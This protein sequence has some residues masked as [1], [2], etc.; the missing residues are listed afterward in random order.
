M[1]EAEAQ[2]AELPSQRA[3]RAGF[4]LALLSL[5]LLGA[6]LR[7]FWL[8]T[9]LQ[10]PEHDSWIYTIEARKVAEQGVAAYLGGTVRRSPLFPLLAGLFINTGLSPF[11]A[12][13]LIANAFYLGTLLGTFALARLLFGSRV[14]ILATALLALDNGMLNLGVKPF[15]DMGQACLLTWSLFFMIK[16]ARSPRA[17][18]GVLLGSSLLGATFVRPEGIV[19]SAILLLATLILASRHHAPWVALGTYLVGFVLLAAPLRAE[20]GSR[21]GLGGRLLLEST[22]AYRLSPESTELGHWPAVDVVARQ[23]P[24]GDYPSMARILLREPA[25]H[26]KRL[27]RNVWLYLRDASYHLHPLLAVFLLAGLIH[28]LVKNP[29]LVPPAVGVAACMMLFASP[30]IFLSAVDNRLALASYPQMYLLAALGAVSVAEAFGRSRR[31]AY[32]ALIVLVLTFAAL[33]HARYLQSSWLEK[34]TRDGYPPV[35]SA[36]TEVASE[37]RQ[38]RE[39]VVIFGPVWKLYLPAESKLIELW[40]HAGLSELEKIVETD[41]PRFLLLA[42]SYHESDEVHDFFRRNPPPVRLGSAQLSQVHPD[43]AGQTDVRVFELS[44]PRAA[45]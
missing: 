33:R 16:L 40:R 7:L 3:R 20:E 6:S 10:E 25:L 27:T 45:P 2:E 18:W 35:L 26:L 31:Q 11:S 8:D 29:A 36:W 42:G 14:A 12:A 21:K 19:F 39:P 1:T 22:E 43:P 23:Y 32:A 24:D 37:F 15:I 41:R 9:L 4:S 34:Y 28:G 38:S 30:Y 5:I 13:K 17:L 44:Y